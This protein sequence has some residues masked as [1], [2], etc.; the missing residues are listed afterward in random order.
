MYLQNISYALNNYENM[1][2]TIFVH[3]LLPLSAQLFLHL[4]KFRTSFF[5]LTPLTFWLEFPF[6]PILSLRSWFPFASIL[7]LRPWFP[8]ASFLSRDH[9][10][11]PCAS[12]PSLNLNLSR[13]PR[14]ILAFLC[15]SLFPLHSSVQSTLY[16]T[17]QSTH[18]VPMTIH[19]YNIIYTIKQYSFSL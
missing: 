19:V 10:S 16:D 14:S 18:S 12:Y 11:P 8:F 2:C 17:I 7:S 3:L 13:P 6:A 9:F 1:R 15:P 4:F 5:H